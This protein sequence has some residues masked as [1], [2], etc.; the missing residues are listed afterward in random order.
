MNPNINKKRP[1]MWIR[2]KTYPG[3]ADEVQRDVI[4]I[5]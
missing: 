3:M 1:P 5:L 2:G 4:S